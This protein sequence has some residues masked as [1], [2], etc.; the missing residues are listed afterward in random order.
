ME[1]KGDNPFS[2]R[3]RMIISEVH[4]RNAI[5]LMNLSVTD[6]SDGQLIPLAIN[7]I[8]I[9]V[10][11]LAYNFWLAVIADNDL[12]K[13][14]RN[15]SSPFLCVKHAV[16]LGLRV[17]IRLISF[18]CK[19]FWLTKQFAAVLHACVIPRKA[20]LEFQNK[21]THFT[22]L[23]HKKRVRVHRVLFCSLPDNGTILH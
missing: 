21:V 22:T 2:F 1:L 7:K 3:F 13:S 14:F 17:Q 20:D 19:A 9:L 5:N 16:E 12:L 4:G 15:Y 8:L 6:G 18:H 23:P 10:T 11:Y